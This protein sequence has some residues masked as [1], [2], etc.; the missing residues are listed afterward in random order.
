M[1]DNT[2]HTRNTELGDRNDQSTW[3]FISIDDN[4][5]RCAAETIT[6]EFKVDGC[7]Y[8]DDAVVN[9]IFSLSFVN[10]IMSLVDL[11]LNIFNTCF[12]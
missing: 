9:V 6:G 3:I 1:Y 12:H 5:N 10:E 8:D 7:H 4:R 11:A 2:T